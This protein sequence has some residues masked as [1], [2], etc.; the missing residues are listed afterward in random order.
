MTADKLRAYLTLFLV[1]FYGLW[2]LFKTAFHCVK[3]YALST[4]AT[5][6]LNTLQG[7]LLLSWI[8]IS[9]LYTTYCVCRWIFLTLTEDSP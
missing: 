6:Y 2:S 7:L 4:P 9:F 8:I 5:D 1:L 3:G